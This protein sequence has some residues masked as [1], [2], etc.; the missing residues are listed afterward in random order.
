MAD[1]ENGV[2]AACDLLLP[3]CKVALREV[4]VDLQ[5]IESFERRIDFPVEAEQP[6]RA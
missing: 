2:H 5:V 3:K 4:G 1:L 6:R